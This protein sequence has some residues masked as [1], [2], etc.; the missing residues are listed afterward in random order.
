MTILLRIPFRRILEILIHQNNMLII[1]VEPSIIIYSYTITI[2]YSQNN[3]LQYKIVKCVKVT[4][5]YIYICSFCIWIK[6]I[7]MKLGITFCI[8]SVTCILWEVYVYV[9]VYMV[10]N[11]ISREYQMKLSWQS[12]IEVNFQRIPFKKYNTK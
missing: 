5:E 6:I 9:Y 4:Y 2:K 11:I 8:R 7:Y 10:W 3:Y 12:F 1:L